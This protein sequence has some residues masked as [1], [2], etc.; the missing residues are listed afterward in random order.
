MSKLFNVASGAEYV[1]KELAK[2]VENGVEEVKDLTPEDLK[3]GNELIEVLM[4]EGFK[5]GVVY[6][7]AAAVGVAIGYGALKGYNWLKAKFKKKQE[8]ETEES[9]EE[10]E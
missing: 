10:A 1:K 8:E 7:A 9:E 6:T 3:N 4:G 2:A 5:R